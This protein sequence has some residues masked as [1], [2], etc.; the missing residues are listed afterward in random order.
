MGCKS[1]FFVFQQ[2][3]VRCT[4]TERYQS[5]S[6]FKGGLAYFQKCKIILLNSTLERIS[7]FILLPSNLT[8]TNPYW[9]LI[10][11]RTKSFCPQLQK[12]VT[13]QR[14][15]IKTSRWK[16][17]DCFSFKNRSKQQWHF[18][19]LMYSQLLC[20]IVIILV[21]RQFS[22]ITEMFYLS[23]LLSFALIWIE[24]NSFKKRVTFVG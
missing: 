12:K 6:P 21:R 9:A 7:L 1:F 16:A 22:D 19:I 3:P 2:L 14:D 17:E 4:D 20:L 23:F 8:L 10:W 11:R 18:N 5:K 13:Q 15:T 24:E